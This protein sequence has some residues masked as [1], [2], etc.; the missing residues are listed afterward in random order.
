MPSLSKL[1]I[2]GNQ[3]SD[4]GE[5][6]EGEEEEEEELDEAQ[7]IMNLFAEE[8]WILAIVSKDKIAMGKKA[9]KREKNEIREKITRERHTK[10]KL[11][12]QSINNKKK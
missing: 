7:K 1:N 12:Q 5:D 6:D 3:Q 9:Q 10:R 2:V 8:E 4:E 11:A